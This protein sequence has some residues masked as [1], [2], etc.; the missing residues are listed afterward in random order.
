MKKYESI[1]T[2]IFDLWKSWYLP[3]T[4]NNFKTA[5]DSFFFVF[6]LTWIAQVFMYIFNANN[7]DEYCTNYP[8]Y[9]NILPIEYI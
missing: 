9:F 8:K 7:N 3:V 5:M 4:I 6:S 1:L 2:F